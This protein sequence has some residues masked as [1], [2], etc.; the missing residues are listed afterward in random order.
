MPKGK[1]DKV[2]NIKKYR[3]PMNVNIGLIIFVVIFIYVLIC[4]AMYFRQNHIRWY[5]VKE[6]YLSTNNVYTGIAIRDEVIIPTQDAGYVNYYVRE[7]ERVAVGNLVYTVDETGRLSDYVSKEDSGENALSN[8]ELAQLKSEIINFKHNF[9]R[10]S[11]SSIYDFKYTAKG[12]VL[13]LANNSLMDVI[14]NVSNNSELAGLLNFYYAKNTGIVE[15]WIDGYEGIMPEMITEKDFDKKR[16]EKKQLLNN[17]LVAQG[18]EIYKVCVDENWSIVIPVD[19]ERGK[20]LLEKEYVKVRFLKNQNESW[21][22]VELLHNPEGNT[23]VKLSFTNSMVTFAGDRYLEVEL[24][25]NELTGLKIP[26]SA[27]VEM[28]FF[29]VPEEYIS[30][31]GTGSTQGVLREKVLEDGT[32]TTEYIPINVYSIKDEEYYLDTNTL[33]TG[34]HLRLDG[35]QEIFTISKRATLIGVYNMNKGYADFRQVVILYQ[36]DEYAIVESGTKY[37]LNVYDLIVL[38]AASVDENQFIYE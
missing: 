2:T 27:V 26:N 23:Y 33:R 30:K 14:S 25:I 28:E 19:D 31:S 15:Y 13:K 16:Y 12:T 29:L 22:K 3:R 5:E 24:I 18:E 11:F 6:G 7:G 37:G 34:D 1:S 4:I 8:S 32:I 21:G 35:S 10:E 38:D 36:N 9:D 20:E 17:N